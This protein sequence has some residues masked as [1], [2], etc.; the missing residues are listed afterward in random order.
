MASKGN[1]EV[2]KETAEK[3]GTESD[4]DVFLYNG[5]IR[6]GADLEFIQRVHDNKGRSS[7]ILILVTSGG[8]SACCL[9]NREVFAKQL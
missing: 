4:S 6:Q 3:V 2:L 9:Q 8:E 1:L 7:A 5:A